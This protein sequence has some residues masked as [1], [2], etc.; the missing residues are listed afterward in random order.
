[1]AGDG[2]VAPGDNG[3][4]RPECPPSSVVGSLWIMYE[5]VVLSN[6]EMSFG[7][8]IFDETPSGSVA[9]MLDRVY[10]SDGD[11]FRIRRDSVCR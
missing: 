8:W 9:T 6:E 4:T 3:I 11:E 5:R 2:F 10:W 1:M 7:D